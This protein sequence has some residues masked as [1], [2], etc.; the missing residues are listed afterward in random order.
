[1]KKRFFL[2]AS[3]AIAAA[4]IGVSACSDDDKDRPDYP[5]PTLETEMEVDLDDA[6]FEFCDVT[7]SYT[8]F[9]GREVVENVVPRTDWKRKLMTSTFPARSDYKLNITLKSPLPT[10]RQQMYDL[11]A[12]ID[13][14]ADGY[15]HRTKYTVIPEVK[16]NL[17][18]LRNVPASQVVD[19]IRHTISKADAL[20]LS[21]EFGLNDMNSIILLSELR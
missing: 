13:F 7:V 18:S 21:Y 14:E 3:L 20:T 6:Y 1:M 2:G 11:E 9:T 16:Y 17:C 4:C 5:T 10:P 15:M 12:D 19:E 8:D